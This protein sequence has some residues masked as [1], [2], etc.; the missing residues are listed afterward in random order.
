MVNQKGE[1][2]CDARISARV[3]GSTKRLLQKLKSKGHTEADVVEYAAKQLANEPILLDWEIGELD[4]RINV[5]ESE[6]YELKARK[7]AK[8]NRLKI[9]APKMI[10]KDTMNNLMKESAREYLDSIIESRG[11]LGKTLSFSELDNHNAKNSIRATAREWGYDELAFLEE[12]LN[13]AVLS[14]KVV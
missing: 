12:V 11:K 14:D 13:Q 1:F 8:L 9:I 7:Q 10:D 3:S 6:L 2:P 4:L 5:V